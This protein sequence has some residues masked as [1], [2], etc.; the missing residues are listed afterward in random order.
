MA[1]DALAGTLDVLARRGA[2]AVFRALTGGAL[3]E[4]A[5][6]A[7]LHGFA[8]SVVTQ[9]VHDLRRIGVVEVVPENGDLRLSPRGR[10]LQG[11]LDQLERW[12]AG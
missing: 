5:L 10:R 9:R 8:P 1:D 12:S 7:R 2:L 3:G 6:A 11:L 4:R